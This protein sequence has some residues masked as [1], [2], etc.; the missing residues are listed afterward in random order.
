MFILTYL[1]AELLI[2]NLEG[3]AAS[4]PEYLSNLNKYIDEASAFFNDPKYA[5]YLQKWI[6]GLDFAGMATALVNS[7]SG[8]VA[9]IAI[10]LVYVI[11]FLMEDT[12]RKLKLES[13]FQKGKKYNKFIHNLGDI[14]HAIR[15]YIW[16]KTAISLITGVVSFVILLIMGVEY[17][18]LWSFLIFIFNFIPYIGPLFSSLFPAIFAVLTTSDLMQFVYVFAAIEG[19]QIVL[20]NFVEPKMMGKGTNLGPV[21]VIVALAFWGMIWGIVGMILAVPVTAVLVII[22]SQI[23]STRFMAILL[24]EK[25]FINFMKKI[26]QN[27]A[28]IDI[29]AKK[30]YLGIENKPVVSY[31]TFTEDFETLRDYLLENKI[32]LVAME[33]AMQVFTGLFCM[34]YLKKLGSMLVA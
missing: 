16:Q 30:V 5:E 10:V 13:L 2:I 7:L 1:V 26:R 32:T 15:S 9:N 22:L 11:F 25:G 8:F 31:F 29:G 17:A 4:M 20:G 27:A 19:V 28:G 12:S 6:N 18:F 24:S 33:E 34:K 14:S 3:I 21:I 23:P